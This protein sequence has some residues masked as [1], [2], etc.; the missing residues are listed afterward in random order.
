M[1]AFVLAAALLLAPGAPGPGA[2]P[3]A[4]PHVPGDR[5][6]AEDKARHLTMSFAVVQMG[7][8]AARVGLDRKPA[9]AAAT[10]LSALLGIGKEIVDRRA[11]GPFS[12]RDLAWDAAG[13]ALGLLLVREID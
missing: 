13:I 8:G 9:A 7:Y 1:N 6:L 2:S 3:P 12:V 4:V 11:G 10:A 5:W